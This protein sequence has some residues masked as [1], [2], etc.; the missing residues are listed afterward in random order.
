MAMAFAALFPSDSPAAVANDYVDEVLRSV[1]AYVQD[2]QLAKMALPDI[3]RD[4][5]HMTR[6]H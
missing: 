4:N 2:N 1:Q 6:L 5:L 3:H